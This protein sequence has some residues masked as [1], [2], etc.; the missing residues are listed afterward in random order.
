MTTSDPH[1]LSPATWVVSGGRSVEP[2]QPLNT[3]I[4]P[5]STFVHGG[6]FG[7]ARDDGTP[8]TAALEAL[9][10]GLEGGQAVAFASGMAA[11]AAVVD[12]LPVGSTIALPKDCYQGVGALALGGQEHGRWAVHRIATQDTDG[13]LA[14]L[15]TADLIWLE[16]PS[17][18]LLEVAEVATI[19]SARRKPDSILAVDNTFATPLRQQ[20]LRM[21]A[22]ISVQSVT[23]FIGGHSD[24][25]MGVA[26]VVDDVLR[27]ALLRHRVVSGAVPGALESYLAVR[28]AR[29]MVIRLE[30]AEANALALSRLLARHPSVERVRYPGM[31]AESDDEGGEL[32]GGYGSVVSFELAGGAQAA[33][34]ACRRIRLIR[35]A[36]SLGS[37]ESTM[38]RRAAIAGQERIPAGLI[39]LS[40]GIE[41]VDDIWRDLSQALMI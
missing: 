14:A 19:C 41:D 31:S 8:T 33:D 3:P 25:M 13:W 40:V 5:A 7:Y 4:V 21:G 18:P 27:Q 37:V 22:D 32:V 35:H 10:G 20:P 38:E 28:G 26:T 12:Q 6:A 39:R 16:S 23:K 2:G 15:E 36:T 29:T 11:A 17:N 30:R 34:A 1:E 9:V 24:L